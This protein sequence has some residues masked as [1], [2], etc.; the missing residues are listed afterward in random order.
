MRTKD[1][2]RAIVYGGEIVD[3]ERRKKS[4]FKEMV[5]ES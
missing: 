1:I 4:E 2:G 3:M 5:D